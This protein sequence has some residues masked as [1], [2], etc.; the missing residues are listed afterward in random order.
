VDLK[1]INRYHHSWPAAIRLLAHKVIDLQ[2]LVTHRFPLEEAKEALED[3]A[4][5]NSGSIKIHIEDKTP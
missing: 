1:F 3:A 5:R 2:P 4:D